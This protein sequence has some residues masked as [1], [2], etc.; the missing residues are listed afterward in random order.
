MS[1]IPLPN[2]LPAPPAPPA[3]GLL[4]IAPPAPPKFLSIS[5]IPPMPPMPPM[6]PKGFAPGLTSPNGLPCCC[7]CCCD[8][9]F[10]GPAESSVNTSTSAYSA[11]P[12]SFELVDVALFFTPS[13]R[14]SAKAFAN[15]DFSKKDFVDTPNACSSCFSSD[16]FIALHF[17]NSSFNRSSRDAEEAADDV[18]VD[19]VVDSDELVVPLLVVSSFI[20]VKPSARALVSASTSSD[21]SRKVFVFIP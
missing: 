1:P 7:G 13:T 15:S 16:A 19:S 18:V 6:L 3:N 9:F 17:S 21:F 2:G 10:L 8:D 14:A 12:S 4:P 5:A 11:Y 20:D